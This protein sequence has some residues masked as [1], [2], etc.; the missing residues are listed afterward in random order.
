MITATMHSGTNAN[1]MPA[2]SKNKK[3]PF[4]RTKQAIHAIN[5]LKEHPGL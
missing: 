4:L 5:G 2:V 1:P 3:H